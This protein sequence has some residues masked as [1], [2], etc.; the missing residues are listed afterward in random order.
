MSAVKGLEKKLGRT[1][2]TFQIP[3][4]DIISVQITEATSDSD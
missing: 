4:D 3:V 1:N 2:Y